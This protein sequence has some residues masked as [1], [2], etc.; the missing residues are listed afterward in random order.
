MDDNPDAL[1]SMADLLRVLG[2]EVE[3]AASGPEA[4][5]KAPGFH[6]EIVLLDLGLPGLDGFEV[7]R[8]MRELDG[9]TMKII[10]VTGYGQ[11]EDRRR[12][13]ESGFDGHLTKP[14]EPLA[15]ERAIGQS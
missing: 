8:R 9:T 4:L 6:P 3:T 2:H 15:L 11:E 5:E 10:A 7:A 1:E 14:V 12:T 13:A